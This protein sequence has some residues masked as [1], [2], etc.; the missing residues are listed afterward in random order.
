MPVPVVLQSAL[1][2]A[3]HLVFVQLLEHV[4]IDTDF[5]TFASDTALLWVA[6]L[7]LTLLNCYARQHP[8]AKVLTMI[9][10]PQGTSQVSQLKFAILAFYFLVVIA[11]ANLEMLFVQREFEHDVWPPRFHG[12]NLLVGIRLI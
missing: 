2:G 10:M 11:Q 9:L 8:L 7:L 3:L 12:K 4:L 5:E 1:L 6:C